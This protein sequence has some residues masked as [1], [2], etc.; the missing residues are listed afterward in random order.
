M[1]G[2][3]DFC[4]GQGAKF[5]KVPGLGIIDSVQ[6]HDPKLAKELILDELFDLTLYRKLDAI[7]HGKYKVIFDQ[8]IPIEVKHLKF[9]QEF[10]N[11]EIVQ[12][13]FLRKVKLFVLVFVCRVFG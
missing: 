8:L 12:L 2:Y 4:L 5:Q 7:T 3:P 6:N 9:W 13:N 11:L 10:F 1:E